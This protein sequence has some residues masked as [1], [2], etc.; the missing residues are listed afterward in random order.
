MEKT[1]FFFK[2]LIGVMF[3]IIIMFIAAGTLNYLQGWIYLIVSVFGLVLNIF[4]IKNNEQ[5][6]NERT[7]PG[8]NIK[9]WDKKILGL[10]ALVTI[11]AYIVAGLDSGRFHW[12]PDF[13][14]VYCGLGIILVL[15][16][17]ILFLIAKYQNNF[18]SSVARIQTERE[19]SVCDMGLYKI[20]RHPGYLGMVV[21]WIGFPFVMGSI[22]SSI[23]VLIAILLLIVRTFLEDNMLHYE[24]P[25]YR[26]YQQKTKFKLIPFIW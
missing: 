21:S 18:F 23:P 2:S 13:N 6:M 26:D 8:T 7:K 19:H 11:A 25:G 16:G 5:L 22:Y 24:L 1:K 15:S 4:L 3:F 9:N 10:L 20:V 12:S 14:I 17:Q